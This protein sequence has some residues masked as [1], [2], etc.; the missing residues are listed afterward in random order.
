MAYDAKL[1]AKSPRGAVA[2]EIPRGVIRATMRTVAV[3]AVLY[4]VRA[5]CQGLRRKIREAMPFAYGLSSGALRGVF[6][7]LRSASSTGATAAA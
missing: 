2:G 4:G 5:N 3:E 1:D 7:G 6:G